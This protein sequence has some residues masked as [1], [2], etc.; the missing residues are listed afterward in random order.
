MAHREIG[1]GQHHAVLLA[2]SLDGAPQ[3]SPNGFELLAAHASADVDQHNY[4]HAIVEIAEAFA[5]NNGR[6]RPAVL[7]QRHILGAG[8]GRDLPE[9]LG[10]LDHYI[11][12]GEVVGMDDADA[13]ARQRSARLEKASRAVASK[14]SDLAGILA[15]PQGFLGGGEGGRDPQWL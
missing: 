6:S 2:G 10:Q 5:H 1:R 14:A 4:R 7:E 3:P 11:D 12:R 15:L 9:P 13:V 8:R